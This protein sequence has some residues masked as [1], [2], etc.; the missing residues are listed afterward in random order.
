MTEYSLVTYTTPNGPR[1]GIVVGGKVHDAAEVSG[2]AGFASVFGIL[3]DWANADA[4]FAALAPELASREGLALAD[5]ELLAPLPNPGAVLCTGSNYKCHSEAMEKAAGLPP[6]PSPKELGLKPYCFPKL[7]R[8]VVGPD[9]EVAL[10][11]P[12]LDWE[13]ELA[14]IIGRTAKDVPVD[15]AL[16]YVAGY[17]VANDLSARDR[18]FRPQE[19]EDTPFRFSWFNHKCFD[20]SCPTGP[21]FVPARFIPDPHALG[22]TLWVNDE[23]KQDSTTG[24]MI[25]DIA[26]QIA[27]Y[28]S[29]VTLEPGDMILTGTPAGTGAET[30]TFLNR[31]DRIR[32]EIDRIG[33]LTHSIA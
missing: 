32:I 29:R 1:A 16:D 9:A 10:T 4:A 13:G 27:E 22:L 3:G 5:A 30:K 11:G 26:E 31:G 24:N 15:A 14:V 19:P 23:L 17:T 7:S 6:S 2:N 33:T 8:C 20:G 21:V 18:F 12:R 25:F 28:S